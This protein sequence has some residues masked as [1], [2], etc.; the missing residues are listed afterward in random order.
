MTKRDA[1]KLDVFLHKSLRRLMK[2]YWPMKISNEEIRKWANNSII[3]GQI[4]HWRWKFIGY[5]LTMDPTK[6]PKTA[7][8]W[9]PEERRSRGRPNLEETWRRT[10]EKERT[11]LGFGSW[12]ETTMLLVTV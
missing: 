11:A 3:R 9:A 1:A 6:H 2:I 12:S 8:T 10:A 7:L 5:V 4:F